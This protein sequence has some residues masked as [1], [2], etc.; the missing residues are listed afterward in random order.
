MKTNLDSLFKTNDKFESDGIWFE[1]KE[2]VG[3]LVRRFGGLNNT[4][5]KA[6]MTKHY[7]PYIRQIQLGELDPRIE[8]KI[9][10]KLFVDSSL[11]D[12]KGIEIDGKDTV[13][14]PEIAVSFFEE[15]PELFDALTKYSQDYSN[16]KEE[17]GN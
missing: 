12:W 2:G 10:I 5:M 1:L 9:L 8:R 13:Y 16:F 6:A 15:L 7:K 17:L 14:N 11:I 4:K 3:F